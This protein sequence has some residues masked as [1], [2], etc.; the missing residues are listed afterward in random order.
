VCTCV[1][2]GACAH[3]ITHVWRSEDNLE[4]FILFFYLWVLGIKH[5]LSVLVGRSVTH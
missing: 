1:Y 4:D 3:T 2:L 5:R